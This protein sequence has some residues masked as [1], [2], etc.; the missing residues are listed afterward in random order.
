L[1]GLTEL[2][3]A[4]GQQGRLIVVNG[5][6]SAGKTTF[7]EALQDALTEPYLLTGYDAFWASMP[8]RCFPFGEQQAQGIGYV[9]WEEGG[10]SVTRLGMGPVGQ[11]IVS[12]FHHAVL[13]LLNTGNNVIADVLF[14][15]RAWFLE[16]ARLWQPYKPVLIALKPPLEASEAWEA[17]R[18]A[19]LAGRPAGLARGLYTA[20][21]VHGPFDLELDSSQGSPEHSARLAMTW[22]QQNND[23]RGFCTGQAPA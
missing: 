3:P 11:R 8:P 20:V 18:E 12:G 14:L 19:T 2:N 21:H 9:T 17:G 7:C 10:K 1:K 6:S 5:T 22:L 16:V 4:P 15:E 13:G 23:F